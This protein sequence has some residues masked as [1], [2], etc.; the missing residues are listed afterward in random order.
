MGPISNVHHGSQ[1]AEVIKQLNVVMRPVSN[2]HHD[3]QNT[4]VMKR[5]SLEKRQTSDKSNNYNIMLTVLRQ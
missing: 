1:N 3:S 2:L 4:K 5:L